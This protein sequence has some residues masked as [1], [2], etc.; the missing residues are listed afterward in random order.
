VVNKVRASLKTIA[1]RLSSRAAL[2]RYELVFVAL[3]GAILGVVLF[4]AV[5]ARIGPVDAKLT[6]TPALSGGTRVNIPP[7]GTLELNTHGGPAQL[8]MNVTQIDPE[9]AQQ[10]IKDPKHLEQVGDHLER[11]V[12]SAVTTLVVRSTIVAILGAGLL[13]GLV[14]RRR[15]AIAAGAAIGLALMV[16]IASTAVATWNPRSLVE[17]RYTGLL[18]RAPSVVGD[19]KDIVDR[20]GQYRSELAGLVTNVT[21]LYGATSTLPTFSAD[22]NTIRVLHVS[23]IH[24]NPVAWSVIG[25]I[26]DEFKVDVIVDTGDLTDHGSTAEDGFANDIS[27]LKRPYVFI[28][29]NHDSDSTVA[30]VKQQPNAIVLDYSSAT[31]G[32]LTFYGAPDPRFTPD[33]EA[34]MDGDTMTMSESANRM[35]NGLRLLHPS[36]DVALVHDP[37]VGEKLNGTVPLVLAGHIHKREVRKLDDT[38]MLVEG[39]TGGAGLRA[40]EHEK[41][42][43]VECS[44]LYFDRSTRTLL[45]YDDITIGGLGLASA[46]IDRH[47]V[48]KPAPAEPTPS[49]TGAA[50]VPARPPGG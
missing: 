29:G 47:L 17:P 5:N 38:L 3:L 48:E 27:H 31:V 34:T 13:S 12:R 11:D 49:P 20:F 21:K 43:P 16:A 42:T 10:V 8:S 32:G 19:L 39:S 6:M 22:P 7:L 45:A 1:A 41:P 15:K 40:L 9:T 14:L 33:R 35:A 50:L 24:L 30:A 37:M 25:A 44:V 2:R 18:S 46:T 36:A 23:D 26:A 28:K 4:G